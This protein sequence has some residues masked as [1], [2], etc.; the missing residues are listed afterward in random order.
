MELM[1]V[2]VLIILIGMVIGV[3]LMDVQV[4]RFGMEL[5]VPVSQVITSMEQSVFCV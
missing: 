4:V 5:L 3:H 2:S 1:G